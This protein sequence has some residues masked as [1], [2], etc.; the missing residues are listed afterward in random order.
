MM[1]STT[2]LKHM[3]PF[4]LILLVVTCK[5]DKMKHEVAHIPVDVEVMRFDREFF[6]ITESKFPSLKAKYPYLFPG[7]IA[8][9][10]WIDKQNDSLTQVLYHEVQNVFG[11]FT[12]EHQAIET[13]FKHVKYFYPKF[14]EPKLLTLV[15]NLDMENQVIFADTLLV[16]SLD[17]YLGSDKPFYSNYPDYMQENFD[18]SHL[19]N[20]IAMAIAYETSVAIPYRMFLERIIA[21]GKLKYAM[22][23]FLPNKT[24]AEILDYSESEMDWSHA[25]EENIWKYFVEKEY[26]YS[27]DKELQ[28]RFLE[29]APFSKFYMISDSESPGQIGGWIGYQI[30][31]AYMGNNVVSLSDMMATPPTDIFNKSKYKPRQ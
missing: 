14:K 16:I 31:A 13:L 27:T 22:H 9:S 11:D 1:I 24:L 7:G 12:T 18:R 5:P 29:P 30:V 23:Q 8:D 2:Y 3:L 17:T 28:K 26:L 21:V 6:E 15:S 20:D 10:I 19:I 4:L 25:N